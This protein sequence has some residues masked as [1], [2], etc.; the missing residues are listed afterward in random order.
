MPTILV[1]ED[2]PAILELLTVNL[3][4]AGYDVKGAPDAETAHENLRQA[5]PDL[6]LLDWMLPGQSGLAFAKQLR[7]ESRT[8][9][10]PIIM[11][12]ARSEE[13]DKIA[14]LQGA[15]QVGVTP[16][17]TR[18]GAGSDQRRLVDAR[19]RDASCGRRRTRAAYGADRVSPAA[20]PA[21][22][23]GTCSYASPAPRPGLGR[24][25]LHRGAHGRC[26]HSSPAHGT[27]AG[28]RRRHDRDGARNGLPAQPASP[29]MTGCTGRTDRRS[30]VIAR[31]QQ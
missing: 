1:V 23:A 31:M 16:A 25:C 22:P 14:G 17:R 27:R 4:D 12:T 2:E 8:R 6:V 28:G 18:S 10:L 3:A 13:S 7:S 29:R 11:V 26:A 19:S 9:E 30:S 15:H 20:F 5:L 24:S 21:C